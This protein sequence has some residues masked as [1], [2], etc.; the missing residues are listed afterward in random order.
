MK[1]NNKYII[2]YIYIYILQKQK[3]KVLFFI[4]TNYMYIKYTQNDN[5]YSYL[6]RVSSE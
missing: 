4:Q 1:E 2:R 5:F 3:I 6:L